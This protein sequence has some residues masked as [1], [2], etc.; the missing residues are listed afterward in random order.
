MGFMLFSKQ[1]LDA[2]RLAKIDRFVEANGW[3]F[4]Y[5]PD[6]EV[7]SAFTTWVK[8]TD[9]AQFYRSYPYFVE[10]CCD[11]NPFF[12]QFTPPLAFLWHDAGADGTMVY[13]QSTTMLFVT[14]FA[15]I[16]LCGVMLVRPIVRYQ[17]TSG[18]PRPSLALTLYF[19]M[20]GLGFMAVELSS[21]QVMTLFLGHPTYALTV[22][23]LGILAFAG[24]GSVLARF[25]PTRM[26]PAVCLLLAGI[27]LAAS[28]GI[29]PLVHSLIGEPFAVRIGITLLLLMV[30]G[31]PM[32]VPMALGIREIGTQNPLHVAWAWACNGAAGVIG[33]NVCMIV[34]IYFGMSALFWIGAGCYLFA[35]V[36]LPRIGTTGAKEPQEATS[37]TVIPKEFAAPATAVV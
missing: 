22:I 11:A 6:R 32:G 19:A 12:F 24:L 9:R 15:L 2:E 8:S 13:N 27:N 21:I 34:M 17:A 20:L 10:P 37:A 7:D 5:A 30:A 28:F 36:L 33:T 16:V 3:S 25:I 29:I 23:L 14:L 4:L 1:P 31:L 26:G 18:H 35:C